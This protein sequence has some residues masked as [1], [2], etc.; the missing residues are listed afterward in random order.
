MAALQ[1][2]SEPQYAALLLRR[3]YPD[4]KK[5]DGLIPRLFDWLMGKADWI[6]QDHTW[7]FPS[8]ATVTFGFCD[9]EN[10]VYQYQGAAY[11]FIGFD[12]LT[13]FTEFQFRYLFSRLRRPAGATFPLRMRA[14]SNPG[15]VG[16][17]W[18]KQRFITDR[19]GSGRMFIPARLTDNPHLDQDAYRHSLAQLDHITR[20]QLENGDW[21]ATLSGGLFK[22]EWFEL[23][24]AAP[25]DVRSVR[26]W[27]LAGTKAT[28]NN[29]PDWTVGLKL[30]KTRQGI[31]IVTDVR[32]FQKTPF[33][34]ESAIKT[35]AAQDGVNTEIW[36]EQDPAQAGSFQADYYVRE[37]AGYRIHTNLVR[38]GK[39]TRAAPVSAQA[40]HKNVKL[41]EAPW[42]QA[43][44]DELELFK[45]DNKGKDDQ[46]DALSGAFWVL[47]GRIGGAAAS[48]T[49]AREIGRESARSGL[50]RS[51]ETF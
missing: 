12:E 35:M 1:F 24:E 37:L 13:Q 34:V 7:R 43:L 23:V 9:S 3:T 25:V 19:Q 28:G 29:N 48:V 41:L 40:E 51:R 45:G 33:E 8:G 30:V 6:A 32:R 16:H 17:N 2:V 21:D 46:V 18:V 26:Y 4:L 20:A 39:A 36:I 22:R 47:S 27:D 50:S 14:G 11:S 38:Q 10:D 15:G 42:N 5:P 31:Y 49:P 44:L